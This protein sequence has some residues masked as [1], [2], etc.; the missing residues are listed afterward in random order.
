MDWYSCI[1]K[2][3]LWPA[4]AN[5]VTVSSSET[6]HQIDIHEPKS[7]LSSTTLALEMNKGITRR[8]LLSH[9]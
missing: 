2:Q 5:Y 9:H 4:D 1:D 8:T 6:Q 3:R 7:L